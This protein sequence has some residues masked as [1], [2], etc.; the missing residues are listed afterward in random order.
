MFEVDYWQNTTMKEMDKDYTSLVRNFCR[1]A[2]LENEKYEN[3]D[4]KKK[5]LE[6]LIKPVTQYEKEKMLE[7]HDEVKLTEKF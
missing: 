3:Q 7:I 1:K 5:Y 6:K 2:T 4:E